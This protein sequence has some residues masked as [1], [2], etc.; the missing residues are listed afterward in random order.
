MSVHGG[1]LAARALKKAGVECV[2]TLS[3]GH[4]MAIYDGCLD[5][6]IPVIDVRHEQAAVHAADAWSRLNPGSIGCA[7]LTA[8]PGVTDGVTGVANAWRANSPIL[9]IGGQ[10][11]FDK[12]RM[13]SLQEMDHVGVMRPITKWADACY[14]TA[15]IPDY[16]EMGV[17][18]AI[19][20]NPGPAFL[21]IPMDV[22]MGRVES[23]ESVRWPKFRR[24][25]PQLA[26]LEADCREALEILASAKRPVLMAGTSVKWSNASA[27][28]N[29]FLERTQIPTYVNGM[30]RGTVPP[31]SNY[32][33]NRSRKDAMKQ[34]DVFI[35]AGVLLDFR[36][37]FGNSIP[38]D[39][40]IIQLDIENELIGQNRSADVGI[41]GNIGA[42][43]ETILKIMDDEKQTLDFSGW[44]NELKPREAELEAAVEADLNSNESPVDPL[45]MCREVRDFLADFDQECILIGDG[46]DIVAQASKVL[47]VPAENG[48]MD[49]GPLGTLGVGMP[50]ALAAQ[51][52]Q[53]DKR[54]LIIYGDGS[55]GLN[56]FEYD[57]AIRFNLPI[58]GIV[59][60]DAAWGQMI[61][62]QATIY[63]SNRLVATKLNY[64]RYD[65]IVEAM[66]GHGEY[67]ER[68]EDIR[69]AL[70][71]AF[72][73]GKPALVNVKLRQDVD[74][75]MKGS[76]Y[77]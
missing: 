22:L 45:R 47:P 34:C 49:P 26:P 60:N 37:G 74:T 53:P 62:P 2:F 70:E 1:K 9:V 38:A 29:A 46:G 69:P 17:R 6:G 13:G 8:G 72:A 61:R 43:F 23:M 65:K 31:G 40:K 73:S 48:W 54:V 20:G 33:L 44:L 32:L 57:T 25:A 75:G 5:E 66:G 12:L 77:A 15:R 64:T 55:F 14:D 56:G 16:I 7:I 50:F 36:L 28:L 3:G 11:P 19:S 35:C 18:H 39:A 27:G 52:S 58:V 41:V 4:V 42:S 51:A 67:V 76:T 24:T 71:R 30:G 63:G 68:P 59:G 10:G 21:E